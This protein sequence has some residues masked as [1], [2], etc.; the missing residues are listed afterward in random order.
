LKYK[1]AK[2]SYLVGVELSGDPRTGKFSDFK[3]AFDKAKTEGIRVSLHCS[4]LPEQNIET[5]EM[6]DF[7]PDRL[8]H[9]IFMVSLES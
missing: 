2:E 9:C 4:E 5:P 1:E 3:G 6:L 7:K 8:G